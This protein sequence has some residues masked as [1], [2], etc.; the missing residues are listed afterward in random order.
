MLPNISLLR[1][2]A[3]IHTNN[4]WPDESMI[5]RKVFGNSQREQRF[6]VTV[7]SGQWPPGAPQ[8]RDVRVIV[9]GTSRRQGPC[10]GL[11]IRRG[12]RQGGALAL[13]TQVALDYSFDADPT[14]K[15]AARQ[16]HAD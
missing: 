1:P 13:G 12:S 7:Q 8:K 11:L 16:M 14:V 9:S 15:N 10:A 3:M 6:A 2:P 4:A 5:R